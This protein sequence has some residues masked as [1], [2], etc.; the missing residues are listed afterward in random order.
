MAIDI[1]DISIKDMVYS[2]AEFYRSKSNIVDILKPPMT[3]GQFAIVATNVNKLV[4]L[5]PLG[6]NVGYRRI[7]LVIQDQKAQVLS[8]LEYYVDDNLKVDEIKIKNRLTYRSGSWIA[9][10]KF[11]HDEVTAL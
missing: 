3:T 6:D 4:K 1:I 7:Q 5:E 8:N 2:P 11:T 9:E 10:K